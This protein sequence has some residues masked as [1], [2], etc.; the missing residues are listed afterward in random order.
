VAQ[1]AV[2]RVHVLPTSDPKRVGQHDTVI[3]YQVDGDPLKTRL[4]TLAGG[5]LSEAQ[6]QAGIKADV[7]KIA[8]IEGMRFQV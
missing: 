7:D 3:A 6:I 8:K 4:V 1:V 2:L 5:T